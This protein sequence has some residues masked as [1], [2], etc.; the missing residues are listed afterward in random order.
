MAAESLADGVP[1]VPARLIALSLAAILAL[2]L[3]GLLVLSM[4]QKRY[5]QRTEVAL[6]EESNKDPLT[7][8][9]NSAPTAEI[10]KSW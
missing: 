10:L 9:Y 4:M 2:L 8:I 7:G 5:M 6:R 3:S 1:D